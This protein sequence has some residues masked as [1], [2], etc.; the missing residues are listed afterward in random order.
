MKGVE[1]MKIIPMAYKAACDYID[2]HHRHHKKPQGQKFAIGCEVNAELVGV[3]VAGR[4]LSRVLDDGR[5]LEITRV[6]TDGTYNACSK[7]Y[8]AVVRI[9]KEMGYRRVYTYTLAVENGSSLKA[10]GFVC[11]VKCVKGRSW[12]TGSRRRHGGDAG[13]DKK[14]WVR[15]L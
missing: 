8:G 2:T 9:A 10:S 4:P 3:A 1:V 11:D 7:L 14:R 5:T 13:I 12:S 6:C 15:C